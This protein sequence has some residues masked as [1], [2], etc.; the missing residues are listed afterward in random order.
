MINEASDTAQ[1]FYGGCLLNTEIPRS[2]GK[3][4]KDAPSDEKDEAFES[5]MAHPNC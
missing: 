4:E 5:S 3:Y 2:R 1:T